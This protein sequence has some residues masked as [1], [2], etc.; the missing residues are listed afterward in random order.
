MADA[1]RT[2]LLRK[3][4]QRL[5]RRGGFRDL[6]AGLRGKPFR[7]KRVISRRKPQIEPLRGKRTARLRRAR[8]QRRLQRDQAEVHPALHAEQQRRFSGKRNVVRT[9]RKNPVPAQLLRGT[10]VIAFAVQ[11]GA[12][13]IRRLAAGFG[14][15]RCE[16]PALRRAENRPRLRRVAAL[17]D[18]RGQRK[19]LPLLHPRRAKLRSGGFAGQKPFGADERCIG[20]AERFSCLHGRSRDGHPGY[21]AAGRQKRDHAERAER[22]CGQHTQRPRKHSADPCAKRGPDCRRAGCG[23]EACPSPDRLRRPLRLNAGKL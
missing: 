6:R 17:H 22:R 15:K 10:G 5:L 7:I 13:A 19:E 18:R 14:G 11:N 12:E 20:H 23:G 8:K 16:A 3:L 4:R 2:P 9:R 1:G 21:G